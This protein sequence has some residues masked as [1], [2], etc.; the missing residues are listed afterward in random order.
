MLV[1]YSNIFIDPVSK[2]MINDLYSE[3]Q[4]ARILPWMIEWPLN[5]SATVCMEQC[6]AFGYP[7]AGVE[8]SSIVS[9]RLLLTEYIPSLVS[10]AVRPEVHALNL[11]LTLLCSLW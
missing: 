2:N 6:A 5:M 4:D 8:V 3:A 1:V 10:N 9:N 7:A 11:I